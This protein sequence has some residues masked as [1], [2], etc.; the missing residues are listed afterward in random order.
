[1]LTPIE[2]IQAGK[3]AATLTIAG[4]SDG[5]P[6]GFATVII[7]PARGKF[8]KYLKDNKIGSKSYYGGYALSSYDVCDFRGQNM[9]VKVEACRA[10]AAVL[11][12]NGVNA[13]VESRYD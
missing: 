1:M 3:V 4:M 6:C 7:N 11:Q 12:A 13:R 8:V 2:I 10:F 5:F 9:D